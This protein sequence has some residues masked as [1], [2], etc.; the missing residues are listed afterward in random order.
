MER[1]LAALFAADA[2]G[3]TRLMEDDEQGAYAELAACRAIID[4]CIARHGGRI[5]GTAG[6]SVVAEFASSVE[7]VRA[8][9]ACQHALATRPGPDPAE[10]LAFRIG[11]HFGD[12]MVEAG[13]IL[14]D[15]I[16][17]AARL[18]GLAPPG[19]VCV[20]GQVAEQV[21]GKLDETFVR[22]G[23]QRLKN[24]RQP[25]EVWCWPAAKARRLRAAGL[26]RPAAVAALAAAALAGTAL[27]AVLERGAE[28]RAAM[29][30]GPRI[31]VLPFEEIGSAAGEAVFAAGLSRDINAMLARA[32]N[33]FV[34]SPDATKAFR[35]GPDCALIRRELGADFILSG[36]VRRSA[37]R[38][39]ITTRFTDAT[40][41]RE[42]AAPGPFN[43]DLNAG[44]V[45][46]VQLEIARKV[47]AE[48]GSSDAPIFDSAWVA[49]IRRK[50]PES[51]TAYDCVL[52]SYWFYE[53]FAPERH[54]RARACLE[55]AVETDPD[56]SL[57][58]SR[59]AF[60]YIESEKYGIDT[61]ADWP[62][63]AEAAA[64]RAIAL[65]PANADAYYALAIRSQML[66]EERAVFRAYAMRAIALNPHD[67]FILADLG[68]WM[69]YSGE[70]E[71][72]EAWVTRAKALNPKHQSWWDWIWML[73]AYRQGDYAAAI[74]IAHTVNLPG[75]HMVQAALA[76][77]YAMNGDESEA[78]TTLAHVLELR[79]DYASDP[80]QPFRT[81]GM[82]TALIEAL[83]E[84]LRRAGLAVP[85]RQ[86]G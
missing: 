36:T 20:S 82:E 29:P 56:Y 78:A 49:R 44:A 1:R 28:D 40:T 55:K 61:A 74:A 75:N 10:R 2:V 5:F 47:V 43:R 7:A 65:D 77:A 57:A 34:I 53:T 67:S 58:W 54:R 62:E 11:V 52:L 38:L 84:G 39:R 8:A 85:P 15:G 3:Y 45:F 6:D 64:E 25:V 4:A 59:L 33:L 16:N 76:A 41:C 13:D 14:G 42:L 22:A 37:E 50:A 12:V 46:D 48:I 60:A 73:D 19:G 23:R 51:L 71:L 69:A 70:W 86:G 24:R 79:P 31:A 30:T 35:A 63:R 66:H 17:V 83:M 80:R 18:E 9:R 27:F 32:S 72:G 21:A 81:R 68:T 26:R